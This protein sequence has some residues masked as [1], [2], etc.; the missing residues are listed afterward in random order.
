M[1]ENVRRNPEE[2]MDLI[3]QQNE[4][5]LNNNAILPHMPFRRRRDAHL[6]NHRQSMKRKR[7][8]L[9]DAVYARKTAYKLISKLAREALIF[10]H[11]D[12]NT[13]RFS[14]QL[15][16]MLFYCFQMEMD[17]STVSCVAK[18]SIAVLDLFKCELHQHFDL[19][20]DAATLQH[21]AT[22][23]L[24]AVLDTVVFYEFPAAR[25][26]AL[27]WISEFLMLLDPV[28]SLYLLK[29]LETDDDNY[30]KR[31]ASAALLSNTHNRIMPKSVAKT[32]SIE[33]IFRFV[34]AE[35]EMGIVEK[36]FKNKLQQI[37]DTS[38]LGLHESAI[39]LLDNDFDIE[40]T[41]R[42]L[43]ADAAMLPSKVTPE[44]SSN[45]TIL[46]TTC[47]VCYS[48]DIVPS[49][50]YSLECS[51]SFCQDCWK[52]YIEN[53]V[54]EGRNHLLNARCLSQE[55]NA[56][57][58]G[59]TIL[60]IAPSLIPIWERSLLATFVERCQ[61]F[62]R[63]PGP[64]CPIIVWKAHECATSNVHCTECMT[65]F[66]FTC[67]SEPHAPASCVD[68]KNWNK[69]MGN[70]K[71]WI[72]SNTKACPGCNVPI[73]KNHGC[74]H[75]QCSQCGF[76]FCWI[77]LSRLDSHLA[78]HQCNRYASNDSSERRKK[79]YAERFLAHE[80]AEFF[81]KDH[82]AQ[83]DD[84]IQKIVDKMYHFEADFIDIIMA[85]SMT[86]LTARSFLKYSYVAGFGLHP[87]NPS[88]AMFQDQQGALEL[89][90]EKLSQL[91][92][93]DLKAVYAE[94]GTMAVSKHIR[95]MAFYSRSVVEYMERFKDLLS[96]I[97][98]SLV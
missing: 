92:I 56:R 24:P 43:E 87:D 42:K 29:H 38:R 19:K 62:T 44:I 82:N 48:D 63:C 68:M 53:K 2:R 39:V 4:E 12:T 69:T 17:A 20:G 78:P 65:N 1:T 46:D 41:L 3:F 18:A 47:E 83:I 55:C 45:D 40:E 88:L 71:L 79:F 27:E 7:Q 64:D 59:T 49:R 50:M 6:A 36:D 70:S 89:F 60:Q 34:N 96:N 13:K 25:A 81:A 28:A 30:V 85:S 9:D 73:E 57:I 26:T 16:I 61:S 94:K 93:A 75:M 11:S 32:T 98:G 72:K 37:S 35:S 84:Y 91:A 54:T 97:S 90:V 22:N 52:A 67:Q 15:P 66:C 33:P 31:K 77:C 58:T 5:R 74:N 14:F 86:L 80:E 10:H 95:S 76:D 51:H 21:M 8:T 23:L